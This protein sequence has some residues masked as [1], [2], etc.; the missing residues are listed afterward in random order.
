[1]LHALSPFEVAAAARQ[2]LHDSAVVLDAEEREHRDR[3]PEAIACDV[4]RRAMRRGDPLCQA[5]SILRLRRRAGNT[6]D[7]DE[8]RNE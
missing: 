5:V 8:C 1:M 7:S 3:M 6:D 4:A 2:D